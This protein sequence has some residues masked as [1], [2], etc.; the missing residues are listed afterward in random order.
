M[1]CLRLDHLKPSAAPRAAFGENSP[2]IMK[3]EC[4]SLSIRRADT[5]GIH[6]TAMDRTKPL[7]SAK[8]R[9]ISPFFPYRFPLSDLDLQHC[10]WIDNESRTFFAF[11]LPFSPDCL[12]INF[13]LFEHFLF[14]FSLLFQSPNGFWKVGAIWACLCSTGAA[15]NKERAEE[16]RM[17]P[18]IPWQLLSTALSIFPTMTLSMPFTGV[19]T[20]KTSGFAPAPLP[21]MLVTELT[22]LKRSQCLKNPT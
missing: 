6:D 11:H 15:I 3:W 7:S 9:V 20:K 19:A 4:V 1:C 22:N 13:M 12:W 8:F 5:D 14:S 17:Q 16:M 21:T 10:V 18:P 2:R